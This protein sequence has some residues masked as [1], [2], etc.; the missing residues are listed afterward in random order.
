MDQACFELK[1]YLLKIKGKKRKKD[2]KKKKKKK[3]RIKPAYLLKLLLVVGLGRAD[4]LEH[5]GLDGIDA[6][7][8]AVLDGAR[9]VG[10]LLNIGQPAS[11]GIC[12][13]KINLRKKGNEKTNVLKIKQKK[14]KTRRTSI[15][16]LICCA[17]SVFSSSLRFAS[18]ASGRPCTESLSCSRLMDSRSRVGETRVGERPAARAYSSSSSS[19]MI[20]SESARSP[21]ATASRRSGDL[22]AGSGSGEDW[23]SAAAAVVAAAAADGAGDEAAGGDLP[24]ALPEALPAV[25][26][27]LSQQ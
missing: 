19:S 7:R 21:Q 1:K 5:P 25:C 10:A 8:L 27:R 9:L 15:S 23:L 22:S 3:K 20:S 12:K 26:S 17:R 4:P 6:L 13:K 24:E 18:P 16:P 11:L 2:Q 14:K